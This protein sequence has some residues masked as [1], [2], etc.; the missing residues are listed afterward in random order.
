MRFLFENALHRWK[1]GPWPGH[2]EGDLLVGSSNSAIAT[3]VERQSRFTVLCKV[4]DKRAESVVQ[5]LITRMRMLPERPRKSLTWDR[6]Q[7][8]A[9]RK[10][11]TNPIGGA[12]E[13]LDYLEVVHVFVRRSHPSG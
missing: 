1:T 11:F 10:R 4:Q 12:A 3:M 6:G 2:W 8:L 13:N 9:A 7:Q 5:S